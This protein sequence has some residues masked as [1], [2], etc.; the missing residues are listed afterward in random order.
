MLTVVAACAAADGAEGGAAAWRWEEVCGWVLG[1]PLRIW[2]QVF[3][4]AFL[5]QSQALIAAAFR[6]VCARTVL[7]LALHIPAHPLLRL[8]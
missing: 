5:Q 6:Q 7:L 4:A 3:E 8:Y 2:D 1:K